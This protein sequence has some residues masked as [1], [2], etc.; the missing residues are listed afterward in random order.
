MG[1]VADFIEKKYGTQLETVD[2]AV[3]INAVAPVIVMPED[4]NRF[5][6]II[7]NDGA[8]V[9]YI[10]WN[11]AVALLNG[12]QLAAAGGI[13]GFSA[14]EDGEI[15]THAVYALGAGASTLFV[16]QTRGIT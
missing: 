2:A 3:A 13:L 8:A 15:V 9:A 4:P 16:V 7:I 6:W 5:S 1:K 12:I 10:G 14:N 11:S